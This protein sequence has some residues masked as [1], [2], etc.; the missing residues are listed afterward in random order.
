M[1]RYLHH[2]INSRSSWNSVVFVHDQGKEELDFW[3]NN[4]R[5]LNGVLFWPVPFV[6]SKVFFSNVSSTGC[7]AFIQGSSLVC[8]RNWSAEES[9]KSSTWRELYAIKFALDAFDSQL[10]DQRVR[11]F[12]D[13][14]K[15]VRIVQVGSMVKELHDIALDVFLLTSQRH[16][17]LDLNWLPREQNSQADFVSK[18]IDFD[19]YCV[20]D[21]I[22]RHLEDLWGPHSVD[23]FACSYNS[24]LP[25]FN[26]R[27]LQPGTEAVDAFSQDWSSENN[28]FGPPTVLIGR[29]LSHLRDCKAIGTLIVPMW[30]SAQFW[31]LLC[32]DGIHLN[33]F[34]RE[35][36]FLPDRPDLFVKGRAKNT[37]FGTKAFKSRCLALRIDFAKY[38]RVSKVG[39]CTTPMGWCSVCRS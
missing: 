34:V 12:T 5:V 13:N 21:E 10:A 24:K 11:C 36:C 8:H 39:F 7:G 32:D 9:Q 30:K 35:C 14:Q 17:H 19:D 38:I 2:I 18:M 1:T 37:L 29:S 23:R 33:S 31:P 20:N 4:L 28:W 22:F 26:S 15:V 16:I 25:R 27:F 3:R 6:P